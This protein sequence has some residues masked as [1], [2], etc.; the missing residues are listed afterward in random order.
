MK[1]TKFGKALLITALSAGVVLSVTSC[2]QSYTVGY[3]YVTG[4]NTTGTGDTNGN[5]YITGFKI[6]HNTGFL[7]PINGLQNTSSGGAN[8]VR[9]VLIDSSRFLYVLNR[10]VN[11]NGSSDCSGTAA[12]TVCTGANITQFVIGANGI[13]TAQQTFTTQGFNPFRIVADSTGSYIYVLERDSPDNANPSSTDGCALELT[14]AQKCGDISAFKVD[15][16]T[17]RLSPIVN[18]QVTANLGGSATPLT[19]FPV[20]ID[21]ID[22]V[23]SGS[24]ILV[25]SGT[26][27]T[28]DMVFPFNYTPTSGQLTVTQNSVQPLTSTQT[29]NK[30]VDNATAIVAAGTFVFVLDND[31]IT[32]NGSVA[33]QSQILPYTVITG[34]ALQAPSSGP[35]P[36]DQNQSNPIFLLEENKGKWLYVANQGDLA[37]PHA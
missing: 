18:T 16:N 31:P 22:F 4:I 20:P 7:T 10:G 1:F 5:G 37:E 3:L 6:D 35:I 11:A 33:S 12:P 25:L 21:P 2:L 28:G 19:Y 34:G 30:L 26:P 8:P 29:A 15:Q 14:S 13:L 36:D 17:G 27:A 32:V 24:N 23:F 9:A